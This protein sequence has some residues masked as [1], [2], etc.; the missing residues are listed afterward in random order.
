MDTAGGRVPRPLVDVCG[1]RESPKLAEARRATP[2]S[3]STRASRTQLDESRLCSYEQVGAPE[4][5]L[6]R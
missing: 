4:V 2:P 1:H 3:L 6:R 5:A